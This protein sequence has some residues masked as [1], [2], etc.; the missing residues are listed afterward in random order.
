MADERN[1][2]A[3]WI[4]SPNE[5]RSVA[6]DTEV[7]IFR[8]RLGSLYPEPRVYVMVCVD[9]LWFHQLASSSSIFERR[10][11]GERHRHPR[12]SGQ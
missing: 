8:V 4:P 2:N 3:G 6:V 5:E 12:V 11:S 1:D 7:E 10:G 9:G